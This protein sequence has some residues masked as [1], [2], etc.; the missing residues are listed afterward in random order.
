M[1][2]HQHY[3]RIVLAFISK[4]ELFGYTVKGGGSGGNLVGARSG[5]KW[6]TWSKKMGKSN[7]QDAMFNSSNKPAFISSRTAFCQFFAYPLTIRP[8]CSFK[9]S[10]KQNAHGECWEKNNNK[11]CRSWHDPTAAL[12]PAHIKKEGLGRR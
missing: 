1:I 9:E 6:G 4:V 10:K 11:S 12:S 2:L 3:H 8:S 7:P 5:A